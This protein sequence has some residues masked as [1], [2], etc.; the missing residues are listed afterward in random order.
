MEAKAGAGRRRA[1]P[2]A[3]RV[4]KLGDL[5]TQGRPVHIGGGGEALHRGALQCD[6]DIV[7]VPDVRRGQLDDHHPPAGQHLYQAEAFQCRQRR[8][9]G[10]AAHAEPVGEVGL[11]QPFARLEFAVHHGRRQKIGELVRGR[12]AQLFHRHHPS[13]ITGIILTLDSAPVTVS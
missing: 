2:A 7:E 1:V 9:N 3:V 5:V 11:N 13:F 10:P 8:P 4:L 6:P 12:P